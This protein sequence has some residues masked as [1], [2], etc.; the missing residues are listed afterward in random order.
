MK[1][2]DKTPI[3]D[4]YL[5]SLTGITAAEPKDFFY[6]RLVNRLA[7]EEQLA[8]WSFPLKPVWLICTLTALLLINAFILIKKDKPTSSPSDIQSFAKAYDQQ[9]SSY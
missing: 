3:T 1:Q 9:I 2:Q 6:D 5:D 8:F 7:N 4:N